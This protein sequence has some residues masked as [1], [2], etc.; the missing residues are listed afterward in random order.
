[1]GVVFDEVIANVEAPMQRNN[2]ESE[3]PAPETNKTQE[4]NRVLNILETQQRLK[5]RLIAN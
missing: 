5:Q 3:L 2:E 4:E 1:M